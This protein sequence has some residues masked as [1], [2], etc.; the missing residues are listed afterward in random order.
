[1]SSIKIQPVYTHL[2]DEI[3]RYTEGMEIAPTY[4]SAFATLL[5]GIAALWGKQI[6]IT[7]LTTLLEALV[8]IVGPL[9]IMFRQWYTGRSTL[10]G[11]RP[12]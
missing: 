2:Q 6:D 5:V 3:T 9:F 7:S 10:L 1:M 12:Q 11:A 8:V 4:V